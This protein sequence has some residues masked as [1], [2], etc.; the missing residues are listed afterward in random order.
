MM[1]GEK[2]AKLCEL[3]ELNGLEGIR[4]ARE[5]VESAGF[6]IANDLDEIKNW[7]VEKAESG[8]RSAQHALAEFYLVG[9]FECVDK[10]SAFEWCKKS[11]EQ[12]Y[13]PAV[14]LMAGMREDDQEGLAADQAESVRLVNKAIALSYGPAARFMG[15]Q[16]L[17]G[18]TVEK[19]LDLARDYLSKGVD[20]GDG[21]SMFHLAL[22]LRGNGKLEDRFQ[23]IRL[24]EQASDANN[25]SALR[26]L[27][28]MYSNG[29]DGCE[30]D[31]EKAIMYNSRADVIE[32]PY[33]YEINTDDFP[34]PRSD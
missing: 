13:G 14:F 7:L 20:F 18:A 3:L 34:C 17:T 29:V 27:A 32:R 22:M 11:A 8:D 1:R 23:V 12:D 28:S 31:E 30:V 15:L 33:R 16:Y 6:F 24:L 21:E 4:I 9:A 2:V 5:L 19:N 25:A 10:K 26:T